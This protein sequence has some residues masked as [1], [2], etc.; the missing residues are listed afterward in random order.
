M[1]QSQ[2]CGIFPIAAS[3]WSVYLNV[4]CNN[5]KLNQMQLLGLFNEGMM[6]C[7]NGN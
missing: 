2:I 5:I 6:I 1:L 7:V 3:P 4:S